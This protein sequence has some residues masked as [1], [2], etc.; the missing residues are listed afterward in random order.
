MTINGHRIGDDTVVR[1][2]QFCFLYVMFI[3]LWACC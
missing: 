3:A 1:V 2:A